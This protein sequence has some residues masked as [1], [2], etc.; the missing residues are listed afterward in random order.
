MCNSTA[1]AQ[2]FALLMPETT[3]I[4]FLR[5]VASPSRQWLTDGEEVSTDVS[6]QPS[7]AGFYQCV[8]LLI[9]QPETANTGDSRSITYFHE[10]CKSVRTDVYNGGWYV[11]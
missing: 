1:E 5:C 9:N 6:L 7:A 10:N 4:F 8:G 11:I 2:E 3:R